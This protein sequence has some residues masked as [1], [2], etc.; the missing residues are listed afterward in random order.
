MS[1][2]FPF[3]F[4][5]VQWQHFRGFWSLLRS[6]YDSFVTTHHDVLYVMLRIQTVPKVL[7]T[8]WIP[9]MQLERNRKSL[10]QLEATLGYNRARVKI[11]SSLLNLNKPRTWG[12]CL[13]LLM[14]VETNYRKWI[15]CS[16]AIC[17]L[18]FML[19]HKQILVSAGTLG[20]GQPGWKLAI[21]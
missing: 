17:W 6:T 20:V 8:K 9:E 14:N 10:L 2:R 15:V 19:I 1:C 18:E 13:W 11:S 21:I 4:L 5:A 7:R 16:D 12:F 3:F